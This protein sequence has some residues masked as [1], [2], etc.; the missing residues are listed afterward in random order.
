VV[1]GETTAAFGYI[2]IYFLHIHILSTS[3]PIAAA[4]SI[5]AGLTLLEFFWS[6]SNLG[7]SALLSDLTTYKER[8]RLMSVVS[9]VGGVGRILGISISGMLYDWG[10]T[11]GGFR[12]GILF[13]FPSCIMLASALLIWF[14]TRFSERDIK[15]GMKSEA[16]SED[17][18]KQINRGLRAF[19]WFLVSISIAGLGSHSIL[20]I[21]VFYVNLES[22]IGA[23]ALDI[24]MIS[25]SASI[26][27]IIFSLLAG[28]LAEKLGRKNAFSLGSALTV[29]TPVLYILAQD[30]LQMIIINSLSG[31]SVALISVVGYLLASDLIPAER[32]GRLFGQYNAVTSA[33]FGLAGTIVGGPIADYMVSLGAAKAVAY[34]TTFQA[35]AIISL[36]GTILFVLKVKP[37]S[38]RSDSS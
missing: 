37:G 36:M 1:V 8:G 34:T 3:G 4:Y 33:S 10:G 20:Q 25:N 9:S 5:I 17:K 21:L 35:A 26:A 15:N 11:G 6:M 19:Y 27:T 18:T 13:F 2:L 22:P 23:S 38:P 29:V 14:S 16:V 12:N 24:A 28:P 7:W 32:R 31:I 30:T